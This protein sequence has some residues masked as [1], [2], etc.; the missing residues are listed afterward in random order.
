[1]K[2]VVE[3]DVL[4]DNLERDLMFN[5]RMAEKMGVLTV[6]KDM[7]FDAESD[8]ELRTR[9]RSVIAPTEESKGVSSTAREKNKGASEVAF[10][11][12]QE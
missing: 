12:Y 4:R 1:M 8:M 11:G 9:R 7:H 3:I 5:M 6:L 10:P 2:G